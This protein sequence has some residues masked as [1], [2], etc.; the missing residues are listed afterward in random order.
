[1]KL[2]DI[3]DKIDEFFD[4]ITPEELYYS[5]FNEYKFKECENEESDNRQGNDLNE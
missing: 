2:E 3:K 5:A 1:M 4:N